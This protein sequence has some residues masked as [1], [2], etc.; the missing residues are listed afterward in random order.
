MEFK[1]PEIISMAVTGILGLL[2]WD[3]RMFRKSRDSTEEK[4]RQ[5]R[6]IDI[7]TYHDTFLKKSDHVILCENAVLRFEQTVGRMI[8]ES[9]AELKAEI[10]KNGGEQ[11]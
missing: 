6:E 3:I 11:H 7:I 5:Q 2:W 9:S 4:Q 10:K 1:T 8:K